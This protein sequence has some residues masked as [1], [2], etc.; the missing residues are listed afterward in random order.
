MEPSTVRLDVLVTRTAALSESMKKF[1]GMMAPVLVCADDG[2]KGECAPAPSWSMETGATSGSCGGR[3]ASLAGRARY[4]PVER[5]SGGG[6][7]ERH[8]GA[9]W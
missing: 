3:S 7:Y 1:D 4:L 6:P 2:A 5:M 8:P 9:D